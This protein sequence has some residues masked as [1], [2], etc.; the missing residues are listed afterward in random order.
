MAAQTVA[1]F[2]A[3]LIEQVN[4][5]IENLAY[6]DKPLL[7]LLPKKEDFYGESDMRVPVQY[8]NPMG[9]S[10]SFT[11]ALSGRTPSKRV[12]LAVPRVSDYA[13]FSLENE[14]IEAS[15][16]DKGAIER[17]LEVEL[18]DS[19]D[20][21]SSSLAHALY[22]TGSGQLGVYASLSSSTVTLATAS[23]A[24]FFKPGMTIGAYEPGVGART[25]TWTVVSVDPEAG[26]FV[27][28]GTITSIT[29]ADILYVDGDYDAKIKGLAGIIPSSVTSTSFFG[30][31]RTTDPINLAGNRINGAGAPMTE[32]LIKAA[33][34]VANYG[35]RFTHVFMNHEDLGNMMAAVSS[36]VF[37]DTSEKVANISFEALK[38]RTG[39]G[40]V[41]IHGDYHCPKGYGWGL[42]LNKWCLHTLNKAPHVI[43][44]D[45]D[46]NEIT[47]HDADARQFRLVYR[48]NLYCRAPRNNIH[49]TW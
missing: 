34:K 9:R 30:I 16:N 27:K 26:T 42:D 49:I 28:S 18:R 43:R 48:G 38:F 11:K 13:T 8:A 15:A 6:V 14:V 12:K 2:T 36:N 22:G 37:Q 45:K 17:A 40:M 3:S 10:A 41:S 20:A 5:N 21:L 33:A 47:E 35:G 25:G 19:M 46:G 32:T 1:N 23:D 24:K 7:A 29:A 39:A 31:D 44:T 4:K